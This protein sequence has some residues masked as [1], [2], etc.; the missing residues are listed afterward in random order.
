[1]VVVEII[2]GLL[3]VS[4]AVAMAFAG[5]VGLLGI[6]GAV[7]LARCENCG[8]LGVGASGERP[9]C[10]YCRHVRVLHPVHEWQ[11]VHHRAASGHRLHH[12]PT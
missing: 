2:G 5:F 12:Q 8:H 7:R 9:P 1:M 3:V 11:L 4:L 10:V 6:L